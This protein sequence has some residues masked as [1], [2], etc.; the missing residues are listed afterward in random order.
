[1][2]IRDSNNERYSI[3]FPEH[4]T[5]A[6][7]L[8]AR[9]TQFQNEGKF[10]RAISHYIEAIE[11]W[12]KIE[13]L[14]SSNSL[15]FTP[16]KIQDVD[17]YKI[18]KQK[19]DNSKKWI[20]EVVTIPAGQLNINDNA[21]RENL[22]INIDSLVIMRNEF[23]SHSWELCFKAGKCQEKGKP[24]DDINNNGTQVPVYGI[25]KG[26]ITE[27]LIPWLYSITG[28]KL[29]LPTKDEWIYAAGNEYR[30][31]QGNPYS[32][33]RIKI[34][35]KIEEYNENHEMFYS[36]N[37]FYP[38]GRYLENNFGLNDMSGN[39]PEWV[40]DCMD[41]KLNN[42]YCREGMVLGGDTTRS[43]E[44]LKNNTNIGCSTDNV[45]GLCGAGFRLVLDI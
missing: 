29:R 19:I 14:A 31:Y 42:D 4:V 25:P 11:Y 21:E 40:A 23:S 10:K 41:K 35:Y 20:G 44:S 28:L 38:S 3:Y 24:V 27:E 17:I 16:D 15:N 1:M 32:I 8:F 9:A 22:K 18:T 43:F 45:G 2:C 39:L 13:S 33:E 5:E 37:R 6:I 26:A 30:I 34:N 12:K 7:T 36:Y